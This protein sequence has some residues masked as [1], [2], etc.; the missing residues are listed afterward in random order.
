MISCTVC[1]NVCPLT[2]V[3]LSIAEE[4]LEG[5]ILAG[6]D[7][8]GVH[9]WYVELALDHTAI[10]LASNLCHSLEKVM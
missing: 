9:I 1:V 3:K 7:V 10:H 2:S 6:P 8:G 4:D 5:G